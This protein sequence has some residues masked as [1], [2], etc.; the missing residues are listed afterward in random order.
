MMGRADWRAVFNRLALLLLLALAVGTGHAQT[1]FTN[2][3]FYPDV[4][5][6]LLPSPL[7]ENE[8]YI[9]DDPL[10]LGSGVHAPFES[11]K[12]FKSSLLELFLPG[13]PQR[14]LLQYAYKDSS[15]S[16]RLETN[17]FTG[18]D[19]RW[20][21]EGVYGL[22][23]LGL[24]VNS[25]FNDR[26]RARGIYWNGKFYGDRSAARHSPLI[27]GSCSASTN[28]LF[29]DNINGELSYGGEHLSAALG[30]G[31]FQIGNSL[32]GSIVLSD[33]VNEYDY[34]LL[35]QR[36]GQF[37]FSWLHASLVADT[38]VAGLH[39]A[40]YTAIQQLT[41]Q[42]RPFL[43]MFYGG[44]V[45]YGN[46]I[47]LSYL[48]PTVFIRASGFSNAKVDNRNLYGGIN[49]RPA[50]DLT[51]YAAMLFDELTFKQLLSNWWGNK[52]AIQIG[53]SWN[54][55]P[56]W[57]SEKPRLG[58]EFTAV[59][60]WTYTHYANVSMFSHDSRPLGYPKGAN[61]LDVTAELNLPLPWNSRWDSQFSCTWQG[62]RGN[63][64]RVNYRDEFPSSIVNTAQAYWL[65]GDLSVTPVWQNT[66]RIGIMA[67]QVLLLGHR[68]QFG[69][70]PSHALFC[71]WQV[72]I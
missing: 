72:F 44:T 65:E 57:Q 37:S 17:L 50:N 53:T 6:Q 26:F 3:A 42:P 30:R 36:V 38:L 69:S 1:E 21:P 43:D 23:S 66:L 52:Y 48:L 28:N 59:R 29:V 20:D 8:T 22:H 24:R 11:W 16:Y 46:R 14:A 47:D 68:S 12:A 31:R 13:L 7:A 54:P 56:L 25:T 34:A 60:P 32:S 33:Q 35:E 70:Q 27:D 9:L 40:K 55:P 41:W 71:N 5:S 18:W 19:Q 51:L 45:T 39:P 67:H 64:W 62:S 2:T 61:L 15:L 58:L 10:I 63:D 49:L 4:R